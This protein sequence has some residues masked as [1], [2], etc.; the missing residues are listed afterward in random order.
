[1]WTDDYVAYPSKTEQKATL[2]LVNEL[3]VHCRQKF[4]F[5]NFTNIERVYVDMEYMDLRFA[6]HFDLGPG[7]KY[8]R[9]FLIFFSEDVIEYKFKPK[10]FISDGYQQ[11]K[12]KN[13]CCRA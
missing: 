12:G 2:S 10:V 6:V 3:A 4:V 7:I 5:Q 1:M 11:F 9:R 13:Y 8:S